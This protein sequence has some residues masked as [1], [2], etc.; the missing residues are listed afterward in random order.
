[1]N[2]V[3]IGGGASGLT[4][5]SNIRKYNKDVQI[6]VFTTQKNV[7]YSPCAIPY[8]IGGHIDSFDDI[9]MH[10]PE[11]YMSKDIRIMTES[12]VTEID[13]DN[14]EITYEDKDGNKQNI[15]YDKLVIATGGKPLMPPIPG[16]D[17]EGV[18]KVR[19]I[20]DGEEILAYSEKSK[21]VVLVGGGAIGLELGSELAHKGLNVTIAEMM[22]QLF[23]RSFDK[24][25]SDKFQEHLQ[26]K[27]IKIL[28]GSAVESI[29][30]ETKVESVTID[31]E[32]QPAD[33]V[34]LSTGVRPQTE[35]AES[36]GCELGKFAIKVN[37]HMETSV[38]NVYAVGDCV[39]V[40]DA[41]TGQI[42]LSP[43]G[44]TA[45][46][47]G[48]ILAKHLTGHE[49]EF[50][51]VLN[52]TVSQIG[53]ME[54]GAVG[55]TQQSAQKE[56]IDVVVSNIDTLS[57][58]RYY[59]GS[60]PL[61]IKLI[62]KLDGTIIGCQMFGQEAVAERVDT[63]TAIMSQKLKCDEVVSMVIDPIAQAAANCLEQIEAIESEINSS[64]CEVKEESTDAEEDKPVDDTSENLSFTESLRAQGLIQK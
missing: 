30:G 8:V 47:Q 20:E 53:I 54:M 64:C 39:E 22:P 28:T 18:F 10:K 1:M 17:L 55:I 50:K 35:L 23:P 44:T 63:M 52:S 48:I 62:S 2:I 42:T 9:I 34:I 60:K 37:S 3:V 11:E 38:E 32:V 12:R 29:N 25:M 56:G 26:G 43:L 57:R 4:T 7:A 46:R 19:T 33:M 58:A 40:I 24:E 15:K 51:P 41:I 49:I 36:I 31:G 61:H 27:N 13:H 21:N 45:V 6:I 5:A 14:T 16:K 59:P